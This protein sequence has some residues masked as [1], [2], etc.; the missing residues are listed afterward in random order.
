MIRAIPSD[1]EVEFYIV[2]SDSEDGTIFELEKLSKE[3]VNFNFESLGK[4]RSLISSRTERIAFCRNRYMEYIDMFAEDDSFVVVADLDGANSDITPERFASIWE[5]DDW[6][7]C[8]AN[9]KAAYFDIWAL[10]HSEWCPNDWKEDFKRLQTEGISSRNALKRSLYSK[11]IKIRE[12][13]SWM[14]VDSA[15]GGLA[16]YR[17]SIISGLR[18]TGL[19]KTGGE[20][21]EHVG[22]NSNVRA[23]GGRIF[24]VP[25]MINCN[26][27]QH[28]EILRMSIKI[29]TSLKKYLVNKINKI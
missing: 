20:V 16:V 2:E 14:E 27:S 1:S 17:K 4:I 25:A 9:Q 21:C 6:D 10:R 29:K 15:F 19:T 12:D 5:N 24:I 3:I 11:M 8:C 23:R 26:R 22:F 28:T 13:E 7:V 18:Y